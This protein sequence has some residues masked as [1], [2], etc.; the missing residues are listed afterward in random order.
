[1]TADKDFFLGKYLTEYDK[2]LSA[3]SYIDPVGTLVIWS[4]FGGQVFND[5]VN[6]VSNDV[7]NYTL[8]LFHHH[9]V[10][11][12][13]NDEQVT[14]STSLRHQY[15]AK[16]TLTFKQACLVL[17]E[18]LFVFSMLRHQKKVETGGVLGISKASRSWG[19]TGEAT[20]LVFTH[21]QEGQVLARQLGLGV[22]GRYK[23]PLMKIGFFDKNYGY[24]LLKFQ[25]RW[26]RAAAFIGKRDA[27]LGALEDEA[28]KFLR[29]LIPNIRHK[30]VIVFSDVPH[31]L[32]K[33]YANAFS[34][35][36]AVGAYARDFWLQMTGLD[37]GAA[38]ALFEVLA[39]EGEEEFSSQTV[40]TRALKVHAQ[41]PEE[42]AKLVRIARVEPFLSDCALLFSLMTAERERDVS[43]VADEWRGRFGRS[44]A[45]LRELADEAADP[46]ALPLLRGT[47]AGR[48]FAALQKVAAAASTEAQIQELA[49]YH[50][51][52]MLARGQ[53]AWLTIDDRSRIKVQARTTPAPPPAKRPPGSW[54]NN[55]YVP[56]FRTLVKGLQGVDT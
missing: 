44:D 50:G 46:A 39:E 42:R 29:E 49:K 34:S 33:A 22:S 30:G 19:E 16:D 56:Q 13:V 21:G 24:H 9:L 38:G 54:S 55:Y 15:K 35:P 51:T 23:T 40:V 31:R 25:P 18:N 11:R 41:A 37:K 17:L 32:T 26:E 6:S 28:Y 14:L 7:R 8:N 47:A 52:V 45:H 10:R 4:V 5:Y 27:P 20:P 2:G 48:R 43:A 1:V 12:L 3:D 36:R 53:P